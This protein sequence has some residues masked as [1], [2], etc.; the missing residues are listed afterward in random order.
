[1][2]FATNKFALGALMAGEIVILSACG[3]NFDYEG[4]RQSQVTGQ[5]FGAALSRAYKEL[6]LYEADQMYD[7]ADAAR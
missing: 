6:A 3:A 7:W 5:E 1:M 2:I 4:L